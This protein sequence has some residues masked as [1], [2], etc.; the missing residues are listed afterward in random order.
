MTRLTF[1]KSGGAVFPAWTPDGK[2]LVFFSASQ[3]LSGP[4]IYWARA[5]G[6]GEP[7]RLLEGQGLGVSSFSPDGKRLAYYRQGPDFGIWTLPLDLADPE[8]PKPG[9]PELFLSSKFIVRNAA[10]SPD[11][12]W[13]A[14]DSL[15]SGRAEIYVRPF[16][17]ASGRWQVSTGGSALAIP[18]WSRN[19]HD[20]FY[21][22]PGEGIWVASYTTKGDAFAPGQPRRWSEMLPQFVAPPDLMPDGKRF[23]AVLPTSAGTAADRPTHVT[24]LLN[25]AEELQRRVPAGNK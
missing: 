12:R 14:Y 16:P 13:I 6:A 15:E 2:H 11:G 5:D 8:H 20:L 24:F 19:G 9:K 18:F 21:Y 7:Q 4:G 22:R 1:L 3:D 17:G 10:F 23:I 25:F